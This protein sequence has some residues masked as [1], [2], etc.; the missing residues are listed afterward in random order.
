MDSGAGVW[1]DILLLVF[2]WMSIP[3]SNLSM[4]FHNILCGTH[5]PK[6]VTKLSDQLRLVCKAWDRIFRMSRK[7]LKVL[8]FADGFDMKRF[9]SL[10]RCLESVEVKLSIVIDN[11]R[12]VSKYR[13]GVVEQLL[14]G[15]PK[16]K[17]LKLCSPISFAHRWT[18]HQTEVETLELGFREDGGAFD[19]NPVELATYIRRLSL[20]AFHSEDDLLDI[21]IKNALIQSSERLESLAIR[22]SRHQQD[23]I[24]ICRAHPNL[25]TLRCQ[26]VSPGLLAAIPNVTNLVCNN[27]TFFSDVSK[28]PKITHL[29]LTAFGTDQQMMNQIVENLSSSLK[30]LWISSFDFRMERTLIFDFLNQ[31]PNLRTFRGPAL[32]DFLW[33]GGFEYD[34]EEGRRNAAILLKLLRSRIPRLQFQP[35]SNELMSFT[36]RVRCL[37]LVQ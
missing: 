28:N 22:G 29:T 18:E 23:V 33:K 12:R 4:H 11:G 6:L 27:I 8:P 26:N 24:E 14:L 25:K 17:S 21:S 30:Y 2:R 13:T 9:F 3:S 7:S 20:V 19:Y 16:L 34:M 10:Y 31:C 32:R 35:H 36:A 37:L 1:R 15:L 5:N